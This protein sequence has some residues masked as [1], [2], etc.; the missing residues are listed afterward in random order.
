MNVDEFI[1]N[2]CEKYCRQYKVQGIMRLH[3]LG[4]NLGIA[5]AIFREYLPQIIKTPKIYTNTITTLYEDTQV[6]PR[7]EIKS[8]CIH[9]FSVARRPTEYWPPLDLSLI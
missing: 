4:Q 7:Q 1:I 3:S 2:K 6:V 8:V 5:R 9:V